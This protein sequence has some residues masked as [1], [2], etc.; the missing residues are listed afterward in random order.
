MDPLSNPLFI[1]A[2]ATAEDG[3]GRIYL[4]WQDCRFR[5][6]CSANDIVMTTSGNGTSW[7]PV[8]RVTSS[9]GDDTLPG[10]GAD[11]L[12]VG[13][14]ARIGITY[15]HYDPHCTAA[16]CPI[17]VWFISSVDGNATWSRPV[18]A[19]GPMQSS[20]LATVG[21]GAM[22]SYFISTTVLPDG[23]AVTAFPLATPPTG[24]MMHQ[25]MYAV[26]GGMPIR[27]GQHQRS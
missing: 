16:H 3:T 20:W 18:R 7:T 12:S 5:P 25:D 9:T 21:Q 8:R 22:I 15:Y 1:P 10:I 4:A 13:P 26:R 14:F 19:A 27:G 6:G 11:P 2:L 24:G 17:G 23:N